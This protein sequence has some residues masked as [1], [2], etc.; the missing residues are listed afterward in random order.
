[1]TVT[2]VMKQMS[3][4][5]VSSA[6]RARLTFFVRSARNVFVVDHVRVNMVVKVRCIVENTGRRNPRCRADLG[7]Y[8]LS[9]ENVEGDT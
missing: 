2:K 3:P 6:A 5:N 1:M 9:Q 4:T 7:G 8:S